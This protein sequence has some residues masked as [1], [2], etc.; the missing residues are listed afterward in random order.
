V[1][2]GGVGGELFEGFFPAGF[3][4]GGGGFPGGKADGTHLG[5]Q[6]VAYLNVVEI[7]VFGGGENGGPDVFADAVAGR[8]AGAVERVALIAPVDLDLVA[9]ALRVDGGAEE[10]GA[11]V[12]DVGVARFEEFLA[13]SA[14]A[15][16]HIRV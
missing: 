10:A 3:F 13:A 14:L 9:V 15:G 2:V 6:V 5:P 7:T 16:G 4:V 8:A 1:G 11:G 12:D